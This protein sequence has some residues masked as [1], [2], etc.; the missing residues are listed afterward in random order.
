M[1]RRLIHAVILIALFGVLLPAAAHAEDDWP[2]PGGHFFTQTGGGAGKG[3]LVSDD[4]GIFFWSEL[5]RLGGVAAVGY[6]ISQRFFWDGFT[7]QAFQRVVFQW[8]PECGCVKFVNLF[9]RLH[10]LGKDQ[11]LLSVHKVPPLQEW[12]EN[13]QPW[14]D[15]VGNRLEILD[16]YP[17]MKAMYFAGVADPPQVNGL[18]TSGV[19]DMGNHFAL[20]A[21]RGVF[22]QWKEDT[23]WAREGEVTVALGGDIAKE[24][25]LLPDPDALLAVAPPTVAAIPEKRMFAYYVPYDPT[26][27]SSLQEH[28]GATDYVAAQWVTI[29]ACGSIGSRDDQTLKQFARAQGVKVFPSLLTGSGWLNH[30][31]LTDETVSAR[32]IAQVVAYVLDEGYEGFDLDLEGIEAR[33]RAAF[34]DFVSR[35]GSALHEHGKTLS[36]AIPAKT[37]DVTTGWAG[38]YDYAALGR[39]A[40]LITIMT[41]DYHGSWGDPGPVAPYGWV[42]DVIAFATSQILMRKVLLGLAFYGYDWNVTSGRTRALD[43]AQAAE[44]SGRYQAP[45]ILDPEAQSATFSYRAPAADPPPAAA[46]LP[47]LQHE[48]TV[49]KP[50]PCPVEEPRAPPAPPLPTPPPRD[51]NE[52]VVWL[53]ESASAAARLK[54]ADRYQTGGIAAWRLGQEDPRFWAILGQWKGVPH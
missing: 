48:V 3:Y 20:R 34:T 4:G 6:P 14:L 22:Q 38:P 30:R 16:P 52:H 33:D 8:Q 26:S 15:I 46:K 43:Y 17:A 11:W 2:L 7:V 21:Q 29:D 36:L 18:P 31:I 25:G 40:D 47:P 28:A 45:M 50:P 49:R 1:M 24:S 32:A 54:L 27:W 41:Y 13:G 5:Q 39:H 12:N 19:A 37:R 23:P 53:E 42:D 44:L 51:V 10:E 35:L 9:D